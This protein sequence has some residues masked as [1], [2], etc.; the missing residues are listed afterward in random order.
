MLGLELVEVVE[1]KGPFWHWV[2]GDGTTTH[3]L[4]EDEA[5][6]FSKVFV[7]CLASTPKSYQ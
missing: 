3:I 4:G 7:C 6:G 5:V 1:G 2:D